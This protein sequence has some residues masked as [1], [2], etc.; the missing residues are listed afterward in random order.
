MFSNKKIKELEEKLDEKDH[1]VIRASLQNS[2]LIAKQHLYKDMIDGIEAAYHRSEKLFKL[3]ELLIRAHPDYGLKE[4]IH[5]T[6]N[7]ILEISET[8]KNAEKIDTKAII[9][10]VFDMQQSENGGNVN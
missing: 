4:K 3:L 10:E 2:Y 5:Q 9:Q 8:F 6:V 7:E 1:E